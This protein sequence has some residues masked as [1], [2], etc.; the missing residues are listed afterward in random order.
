MI[1]LT[2]S[3]NL[4]AEAGHHFPTIFV[5]TIPVT[6]PAGF[7]LID[8]LP[9]DGQAFIRNEEGMVGRGTLLKLTAAGPGRMESL[10]QQWR[11]LCSTAVIDD[12]TSGTAH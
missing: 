7:K 4:T 8:A 5:K 10:A 1:A 2:R 6:L 3:D 12:P 11:K 9:A